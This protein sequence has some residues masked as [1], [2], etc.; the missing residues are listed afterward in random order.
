MD[1]AALPQRQAAGGE[2]PCEERHVGVVAR[3]QGALALAGEEAR[4]DLEKD[5][6]R[7]R[8]ELGALLGSRAVKTYLWLKGK[9]PPTL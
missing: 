5:N 9:K 2:V 1:L 4:S 3:Q 6:Q 8:R 7:L